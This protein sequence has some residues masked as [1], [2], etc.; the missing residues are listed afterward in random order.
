MKR[1]TTKRFYALHS[2]V[3][4]I[5]AVLMFVVC[6]T[7]AVSVFGRPELKIWSNEEIQQ[8]IPHAP[9]VI[10]ELVR[11]RAGDVPPRYL[12]S[13]TVT[14]PA[15]RRAPWLSVAFEHE[16]PREGGGEEHRVIR[17]YH[18]PQTLEL[19][20][21]REG[22]ERA[23]FESDRKDMA[24]FLIAF[25]ADL[26]LGDP[27]GLMLTGLLGLTLFASIVTGVITHRKILREAFTFRPFRSLRLLFTDSHK[28][29]GVWGLLFHATIGFT[30]AFLGLAVVVL[31]PAAAVVA[32]GGD[33]EALADQYLPQPVVEETGLP[34]DIRFADALR[35]AR[36]NGDGDVL[37]LVLHA[38]TDEGGLVQVFSLAGEGMVGSSQVFRMADGALDDRFTQFSRLGTPAGPVLDTMF[39]LHFGNFAGVTVKFIWFILGLS[40]AMLAVTGMMIWLE[41][42]TYGSAGSLSERSYRR[43]G[44][45]T[46]GGCC[47]VV[48]AV[49]A[50]FHAQL[51]LAVP[52]A[53][54]GFWLGVVFFGAW[55]LALL[56]AALRPSDYRST[57]ELLLLAGAL[58]VA[59][60]VLSGLLRENHLLNVV[61]GGHWVSAG[62]DLTLLLGGAL[63]LGV[64]WRLPTERPVRRV[65]RRDVTDA[66]RLAGETEAE[67]RA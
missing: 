65:R 2:W 39:P 47:G 24:D 11:K 56:W 25:H 31:F 59:A 67:A 51:L 16:A 54:S 13:I 1:D 26:H 64:A 60:P 58:H 36:E 4:A 27:V 7:G 15:V 12:E 14:F 49:A 32:V 46:A 57:R 48:I 29:M 33:V 61:Q 62:V 50:L 42:R 8:H 44:K 18:H 45:L 40:T 20:E 34:G 63:M 23:L 28:V 55:A 43:I 37:Q 38:P 6:Y 66:D 22:E 53:E 10:E 19:F 30:G 21:R 3:G 9:E 35:Q 52:A 41:R 17:F 5:T